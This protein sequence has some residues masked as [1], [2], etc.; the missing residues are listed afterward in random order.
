MPAFS[1]LTSGTLPVPNEASIPKSAMGDSIKRGKE[2]LTDS[3]GIR[4]FFTCV[5]FLAGLFS[6]NLMFR[7]TL[8]LIIILYWFDRIPHD[9]QQSVKRPGLVTC[10]SPKML[11]IA[12]TIIRMIV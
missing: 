3:F 6:T 8:L 5:P 11:T 7:A 4:A 10:K 12:L 1:E 9:E 2:L